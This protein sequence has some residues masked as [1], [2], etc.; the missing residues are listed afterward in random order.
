MEEMTSAF[1]E[2]KENKQNSLSIGTTTVYGVYFFPDILRL[3][4]QKYP[5]VRINNCIGN[6]HQILEMLKNGEIE[7][8][9]IRGSE[10]VPDDYSKLLV[11]TENLIFIA[12]PSHTLA[13]GDT[14]TIDKIKDYSFIHREKGSHTR[15]QIEKYFEKHDISGLSLLELG[16]IESVKKSVADGIGISIAPRIAVE[17]ELNDKRLMEIKIEGLS[18]EAEYFLIYPEKDSLSGASLNF[19]SIVEESHNL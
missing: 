2:I 4:T 6:S 10:G 17:T 1:S 11:H 5:S 18:L 7:I 19:I 8:A 16:N 15:N 12:S 13:T 3:F 14:I 9:I